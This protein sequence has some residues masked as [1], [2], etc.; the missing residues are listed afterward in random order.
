MLLIALPLAILA[1]QTRAVWLSFAG[2][3]PA[4]I[5]VSSSK[6]VRRACLCLI[7]AGGVGPGAALSFEDANTSLLT[8]LEERSPVEFRV[9]MYRA[10][11]QMFLEKPLAGLGSGEL[12]PELAKRINDFHQTPSSF[13]TPIWKS[14]FSTAWSDCSSIYGSPPTC[15]GWAEGGALRCLN[16]RCVSG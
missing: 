11:L 4:L 16:R 3:I 15:S 12:Q 1:T 14:P 5:F 9:V 2:C 8:R 7:L 6:R 10:G 13:T